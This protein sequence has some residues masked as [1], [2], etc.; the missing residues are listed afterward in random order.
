M[1]LKKGQCDAV[2]SQEHQVCWSMWSGIFVLAVEVISVCCSSTVLDGVFANT[3]S[4]LPAAAA[5]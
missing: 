2:T 4:L 3:L 1:E 5:G